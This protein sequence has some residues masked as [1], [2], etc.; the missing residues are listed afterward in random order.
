L[1]YQFTVEKLERG[2]PIH[3]AEFWLVYRFTVEKCSP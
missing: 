3:R 2:V 1:V